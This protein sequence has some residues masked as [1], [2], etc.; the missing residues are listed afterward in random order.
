MC[1]PSP[2]RHGPSARAFGTTTPELQRIAEWLAAEGVESVATESTHVYWISLCEL[3]NSRGIEVLLVNARQLCH[4][5]GCK[6]DLSDCNGCTAHN[7]RHL[8]PVPPAPEFRSGTVGRPAT[9]PHGRWGRGFF[10]R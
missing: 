10:T 2:A 8:G 7:S 4:V 6:T 3:L 5:P 1:V 9:I